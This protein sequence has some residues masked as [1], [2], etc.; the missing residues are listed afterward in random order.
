MM[1]AGTTKGDNMDNWQ[2]GD[3][4]VLV[5]TTDTI[6]KLQPGDTG[7]V[8]VVDSLGTVGVRWDN[9]SRLGICED[10]GDVIRKEI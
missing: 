3:R 7:T 6:T 1:A 2:R 10:A 4:V 8:T 9:G 5:H